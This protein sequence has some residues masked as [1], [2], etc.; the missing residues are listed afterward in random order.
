MNYDVFLGA[1]MINDLPF[2]SQYQSLFTDVFFYQNYFQVKD[3]IDEDT[4]LSIEKFAI[5]NRTSSALVFKFPENSVLTEM[6]TKFLESK[7]YHFDYLALFVCEQIT[8]ELSMHLDTHIVKVDKKNEEKFFALKSI[9]NKELGEDFILANIEIYKKLNLENSWVSFMC[10]HQ[11]VAIGFIDIIKHEHNLEIYELFVLSEYRNKGI[12]SS[13]I[14][15]AYDFF[16]EKLPIVAVVDREDTP[17]R[18]YEKLGFEEN[19]FWA[20]CQKIID[21]KL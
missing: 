3:I 6:F 11:N 9:V 14:T 1:E 13:L 2:F 10:I 18:M 15:K 17:K 19:Y 5:D 21:E 12:A 7:A 4:F 16:S 20:E 8:N